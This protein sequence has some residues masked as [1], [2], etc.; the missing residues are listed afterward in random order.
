[1]DP[2]EA[3][4]FPNCYGN[5]FADS[6]W[7]R[8]SSLQVALDASGALRVRGPGATPAYLVYG[9]DSGDFGRLAQGRGLVVGNLRRLFLEV[10]STGQESTVGAKAVVVEFSTNGA[11]LGATFHPINT[12]VVHQPHPAAARFLI[13]IRFS[14]K[15]EIS[16]LRCSADGSA[17][18]PAASSSIEAAPK[19]AKGTDVT[20]H[21]LGALSR[22]VLVQLAGTLPRSNGTRHFTRRP[23]RVAIVS[24]IY[25]FNQYKDVFEKVTPLDP[26]DFR[27]QLAAEE[28]DLFLY[29]T[30]WQGVAAGEWRGQTYRPQL[31]GALDEIIEHFRER[32]L[33]TVFQSIEDPSNYDRFLPLARRFDVVL[34]SDAD[35]IGKYRSDLGHDRVFYGEYAANTLLNNPIG[36]FRPLLDWAF[37]AGSFPVRYPERCA[38]MEAVFDS[39]IESG[40]PLVIADRNNGSAEFG[41]PARHQQYCIPSFE[42]EALQGVHK[43][44]RYNLNFNSIKDSPTM[45]AMR[46]YELQAQGAYLISNYAR[47]VFNKF[48]NI[49]LLATR[50]N[51]AD[52]HQPSD[53]DKIA[54]RLAGVRAVLSGH[55]G[56]DAADTIL[57]H[58]GLSDGKKEPAL[59]LVLLM[60]EDEE[61]RARYVK[62]T[63]SES[64]VRGRWEFT[65]EDEL[66]S[67]CV[68]QGVAYLAP[69]KP[70][71][72]YERDYLLDRINC[73]KFADVDYVTHHVDH[74][75][76][77]PGTTFGHEYCDQL[78]RVYETVFSLRY[79]AASEWL[80]CRDGDEEPNGYDADSLQ[81]GFGR[82]EKFLRVRAARSEHREEPNPVLSVIVPVFNNGRFLVN[83]CL[84]SLKR[85]DC[86]TRMEIVL[87]DDGSDDPETEDLLDSLER[88]HGVVLYR[89][90]DGGSGSASRPRNT[91]ID[92]AGAPLV[93]FLDPDNEISPHGYDLLLKR[94][95]EL[96]TRGEPVSFVS[97]YQLKVT[98]TSVQPIGRHTTKE[99]SRIEN[100]Q[101]V[102][103]AR[104][105]FPVIS[106][107]AAVIEKALLQKEALRFVEGAAGQDTLFGW[108]LAAASGA[109]AFS[110]DAFLV[111][112]AERDDSITNAL[113]VE[114]FRK[115]LVME[116]AQVGSLRRLGFL[117]K[118]REHHLESFID[119]WY[120]VKL[121]HVDVAERDACERIVSQIR[122]LYTS[123]EGDR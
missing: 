85:Q 54:T 71:S 26:S 81:I 10:R 52:L 43:L 91:G 92:L 83:T 23:Q 121:K 49:R 20:P 80:T 1:M 15:G 94:H 77:Q 59:V 27:E 111:Y 109:G 119:G 68:E 37:F 72:R 39:F 61:L 18:P 110:G 3:V 64:V 19:L 38:D 103:F 24:D 116:T 62:Q 30:G 78:G 66:D 44:F 33:P 65:T 13:A 40:Y 102:F 101:S 95:E 16:I 55:T 89:Y 50:Q 22:D 82:A 123:N 115:K 42:H 106:T 70:G 122:R 118:Y 108:E 45:C 46:V 98:G 36:A 32:G 12:V 120:G 60:D 31:L 90:R 73:F 56:F 57:K 29:I 47:S 58:A 8:P 7:T 107:Q 114:Y 11:R 2:F 4:S 75:D 99:I 104:G 53:L 14:G 113:G 79:R 34:T 21:N 48:P 105:V 93:A 9:G 17:S 63:Y 41:F 76:W 100:L 69:W 87:V 96:R 67:F 74:G 117:E 6:S 5:V 112:Y 35:C 28:Y 97:G 88:A 51:L 86:W 84:P 25:M